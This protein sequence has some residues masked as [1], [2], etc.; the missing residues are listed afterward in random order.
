MWHHFFYEGNIHLQTVRRNNQNDKDMNAKNLIGGMIV[1][2]A[3]GVAAGLL[4]APS[5]GEKTRKKLVK[6][7][8]KLKNNVKD[9]VKSSVGALGDQFNAKIEQLAKTGK[10]TI[11]H[12]SERVKL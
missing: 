1:G 12:V 9:Y 3:L 11:N 6:G 5:S 7:S 2:I 4:L 10:E 8:M